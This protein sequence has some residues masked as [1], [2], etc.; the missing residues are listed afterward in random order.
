MINSEIA[1]RVLAFFAVALAAVVQSSFVGGVANGDEAPTGFFIASPVAAEPYGVRLLPDD[2]IAPALA[3]MD[4]APAARS[5]LIQR[6]AFVVSSSAG[7]VESRFDDARLQWPVNR[8]SAGSLIELRREQV[9]PLVL[10]A[11]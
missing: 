10:L 9:A 4:S 8:D 5:P 2:L 1:G 7:E 11:F 3:E 6:A